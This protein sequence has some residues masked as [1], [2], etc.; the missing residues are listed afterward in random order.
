MLTAEK[1]LSRLSTA[2]THAEVLGDGSAAGRYAGYLQAFIDGRDDTGKG[3]KQ[4]ATARAAVGQ[5]P[6]LTRHLTDAVKLV[7]AHF[8]HDEARCRLFPHCLAARIG[9]AAVGKSSTASAF[10]PQA[11]SSANRY[12]EALTVPNRLRAALLHRQAGLRV[13]AWL[14]PVYAV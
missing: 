6:V 11:L 8:L 12:A 1:L 5:R 14:M 10:Q 3:D 2:A 9:P 13:A 7:A 4:M